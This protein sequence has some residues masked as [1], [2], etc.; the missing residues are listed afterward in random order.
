MVHRNDVKY[1]G[2]NCVTSPPNTP[3]WMRLRCQHSI[4]RIVPVSIAGIVFIRS[5]RRSRVD[6]GD[7]V[8]PLVVVPMIA[9]LWPI[10]FGRRLTRMGRL[11][12]LSLARAGSGRPAEIQVATDTFVRAARIFRTRALIASRGRCT[13]ARSRMGSTS[14]IAA[15]TRFASDPITCSL[16]PVTRITRTSTPRGAMLAGLPTAL[17]RGQIGAPEGSDTDWQSSRRRR[18][19]RSGQPTVPFAEISRASLISTACPVTRSLA[20]SVGSPGPTTRHH[21]DTG[22]TAEDFKRVRAAYEAGLKAVGG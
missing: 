4:H 7:S 19:R 18:H 12:V 16:A 11:F 6:A 8:A 3:K 9:S 20:S 15:T 10:D 2:R 14:A 1:T 17:T 13:L 22:G 5:P 21:P